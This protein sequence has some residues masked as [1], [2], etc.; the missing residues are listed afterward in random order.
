MPTL[1]AF[2]PSATHAPPFSAI[3]TM[4]GESYNLVA[5]WNFYR[6]DW[7]ISL[8]DQS[9]NIVVNQ[10]LIGSPPDADIYLA[11]GLFTTST[12]LY[13]VSTN[14]FEQNP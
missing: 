8:T 7:Y 10:P 5:M 2:Q 6:G 3:V 12:L 14:Q 1:I 4:D 9:G 13:R 11:P